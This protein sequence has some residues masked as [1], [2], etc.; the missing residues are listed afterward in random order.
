MTE[1]E[2]IVNQGI[3]S[4]EF[5]QKQVICDFTVDE[6]KKKIWAVLLDMWLELD[7]ICKKH[8]LRYFLAYGTLLGAVR[9]HGFVPWDDDFDVLMFRD[10]YEKLLSLSDE[11]KHPYFLQTPYTDKDAFFS[12]AKMRNSN[13]S[14]ISRVFDH[15]DINFGLILDIFPMDNIKL[16]DSNQQRFDEIKALVI[17]NSSYMRKDNPHLSLENLQRVVAY[18]YEDPFIVYE[19]I[20]KLSEKYNSEDTEFCTCSVMTVYDLKKSIFYK[21][22]F[23]ETIEMDFEGFKALVPKGY[24]RI[25]KTVYGDYMQFPSVEKRGTWHTGIIIDADKPYKEYITEIRRFQ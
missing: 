7:R 4:P 17:K 19:R 8:G 20:Q 21:S 5:L 16:E 25:L 15:L 24:D 12:Y 2:R 1:C 22:D 9:H 14:F 13:S 10:D 11:F 3:L 6:N 23:A 18:E